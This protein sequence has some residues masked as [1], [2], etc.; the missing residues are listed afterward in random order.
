M[1]SFGNWMAIIAALLAG[2]CALPPTAPS[3]TAERE[4]AA[5]LALL[6]ADVLDLRRMERAQPR[7]LPVP[8]AWSHFAPAGQGGTW[9]IVGIVTG[10]DEMDFLGRMRV[11]ESGPVLYGVLAAERAHPERMVLALRG[12]LAPLEWGKDLEMMLDPAPWAD[13][14]RAHHGFLSIYRSLRYLPLGGT[15]DP[16]PAAQAFVDAAKGRSLTVVGHSLGAALAT[17]LALDVAA[18]RPVSALFFAAPRPGNLELAAEVVRRVP[19]YRVYNGE[20]DLVPHFPPR[21]ASYQALTNVTLLPPANAALRLD[22]DRWCHHH[23]ISYAAMLDP[24]LMSLSAW[25]QR[26]ER[27]TQ[28]RKCIGSAE[29]PWVAP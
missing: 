27:S 13:G 15:A 16:R 19:G 9:E 22:D 2:A 23:S 14:A 11:A 25:Q 7:Q 20:L 29:E 17:Y 28:P 21:A 26:L 24:A 18:Q 3:T 8:P 5:T 4:R 6:C 1:R 12:T 10:E